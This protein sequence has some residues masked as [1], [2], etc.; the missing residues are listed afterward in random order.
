MATSRILY[1]GSQIIH[2]QS[3]YVDIVVYAK[4][5]FRMFKNMNASFILNYK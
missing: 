5:Y 2:N 4:D 3:D 1:Y